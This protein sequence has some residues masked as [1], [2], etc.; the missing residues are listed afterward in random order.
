MTLAAGI[1][2]I[3]CRRRPG[4]GGVALAAGGERATAGA[5]SVAGMS[6]DASARGRGKGH[7]RRR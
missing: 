1:P 7:A 2:P 3:H 5:T 6:V 4:E